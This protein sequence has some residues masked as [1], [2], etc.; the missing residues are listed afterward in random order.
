[1]RG[2]VTGETGAMQRRS[3]PRSSVTTRRSK[4]RFESRSRESASSVPSRSRSRA[5][6]GASGKSTQVA[7]L[8][9]SLAARGLRVRVIKL[10]RQGPLSW[11]SP[12][13]SSGRSIGGAALEVFR[14]SR[15]VKL[16]D[17][18]RVWRDE[19]L[20]AIDDRDVI[21][22]DRY[23]ETHEAA[24]GSQL[25]WDVAQHPAL[26]VF[27]AVDAEFLLRL[28]ADAALSRIGQRGEARSADEHAT[29]LLGYATCFDRIAARDGFTVLDASA[30]RDA[31][32]SAILDE[33][34]R[35]V[36]S[37]P[38]SDQTALSHTADRAS[39]RVGGDGAP[40]RGSGRVGSARRRR[41]RPRALRESATPR[42]GGVLHRS[43][44]DRG[45]RVAGAPRSADFGGTRRGGR[46]VARGPLAAPR[47]RRPGG[48]SNN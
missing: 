29:G 17:S 26:A 31:N 21:V 40:H 37:K 43:L 41:V 39:L 16:V 24:A 30:D 25:A 18:L 1:M 42:R 4:A 19:V 15:V 28:D 34:L 47:V 36:A 45:L 6:T 23:L 13:R 11:S 10:Y 33:T 5:S 48:A 8:S 44:L 35:L 22:F 12:T 38:R 7:A 14:A 2:C 46:V 3:A 9:D 20:P 27:P 32:V